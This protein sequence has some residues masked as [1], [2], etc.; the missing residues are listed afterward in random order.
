[1]KE[2]ER[3]AIPVN[4]APVRRAATSCCGIWTVGAFGAMPV[5]DGSR[6]RQEDGA[7]DQ[8][9]MRR[10]SRSGDAAL[11]RCRDGGRWPPRTKVVVVGRRGRPSPRASTSRS[12]PARTV[13]PGRRW[14]AG[15]SNQK[16]SHEIDRAPPRTAMTSP[17]AA[18]I[19]FV[20]GQAGLLLGKALIVAARAWR[21][22]GAA[23]PLD[24][25]PQ[26]QLIPRRAEP[27]G[28]GRR[29]GGRRSRLAAEVEASPAVRQPS[30]EWCRARIADEFD[31]SEVPSRRLRSRK[32]AMISVCRVGRDEEPS[33]AGAGPPSGHARGALDSGATNHHALR[34]S[35]SFTFGGRATCRKRSPTPC[36]A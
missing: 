14:R 35:C 13:P 31:G 34:I 25:P 23:D 36:A 22:R 19:V 20:P 10:A 27:A 1:M 9:P 21:S 33:E 3:E 26:D 17:I 32:A 5:L 24:D 28:R 8:Q 12:W 15:R 18:T 30:R 4:A 16:P 2:G 6:S 7:G 11:P 29:G